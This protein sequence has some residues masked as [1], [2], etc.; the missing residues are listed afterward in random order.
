[1]DADVF[2]HFSELPAQTTPTLGTEVSFELTERAGKAVAQSLSLLAP[3]SVCLE[4]VLSGR[5][6]GRIT[7]RLQRTAP[8]ARGALTIT[9]APEDTAGPGVGEVLAFGAGDAASGGELVALELGPGDEVE[10]SVAVDKRNGARRATQ[11]VRERRAEGALPRET[12]VIGTL[13][14]G[15]GFIKCAEREARV[16][17]H[18]SELLDQSTDPQVGDGAVFEVA[19]EPVAGGARK[20]RKLN[21]LRVQLLPP[22]QVT[23]EEELPGTFEGVVVTAPPSSQARQ[24]ESRGESEVPS[25]VIEYV[26]SRAEWAGRG[27]G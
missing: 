6:H 3:G 17:F 20:A 22:G 13:K 1:M 10:F 18:F 2:F 16:F 26:L 24:R 23:F 27:E 8:E 25:G 19:E 15:F 14:A 11:M 12:G 5:W 7:E 4:E 9:A 21:A